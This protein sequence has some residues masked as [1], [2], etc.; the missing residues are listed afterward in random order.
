MYSHSDHNK[1]T[2]EHAGIASKPATEDLPYYICW[3]LVLCYSAFY[4]YFDDVDRFVA[5]ALALLAAGMVVARRP[6]TKGQP[7]VW[8]FYAAIATQ[9]LTWGV[10]NLFYPEFAEHSPKVDR[11]G[12]WLLLVPV[13]F[14]T[15]KYP[16]HVFLMWLSALA[17]LLAS[18][19]LSGGGLS[20]IIQGINHERIFFGLHNAEH[21]GMLFGVANIGLTVF[22]N[23]FI[24]Y[25]RRTNTYCTIL[26]YI[27]YAAAWISTLLAILMS[28]TR[29]IWLALGTSIA[30]G[31]IVFFYRRL[32]AGPT[33][34]TH[35]RRYPQLIAAVMAVAVIVSAAMFSGVLEQRID[36]MH[37]ENLL[38][39]ID[40]PSE[41]SDDS[42]RIRLSTWREAID[43]IGKRPFLG[44][45]GNGRN[46]VVN[47]TPELSN[48]E[49]ERFGHLHN[50]YLDTVVNFGVAGLLV[51]FS[52]FY[53]IHRRVLS[54]VRENPSSV[55][56]LYF[57]ILFLAYWMI[58]NIFESYMFY[59]TGTY[60]LSIIGGGLLSLSQHETATVKTPKG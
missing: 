26:F 3:L 13:L 24:R 29:A 51:M 57:W 19:W 2:R 7:M 21:M 18:P 22:A 8:L 37:P 4:L 16:R 9:L 11:L 23:R 44:W 40:K 46:A 34:S 42:V 59:S 1:L 14:F 49:K 35:N 31:L 43:W 47:A 10:G 32:K 15:R 20:E 48:Y 12:S 54:F 27:L 28:Q 5:R 30:C 58:A 39:A 25:T 52:L 56:V 33:A 17:T 38:V 45:G 60:I 36:L 6:Y 53:I 50:S 55:D 41:A